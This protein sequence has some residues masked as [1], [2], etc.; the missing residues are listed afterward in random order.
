M[1]RRLRVEYQGAVFHV[2]QRGNNRELIFKSDNDK[3]FFI[4]LLKSLMPVMD[5][6]IY[7]FVLMDNHYHLILRTLQE[8]LQ[9]IMHRI[10]YK[11]SRYFNIKYERK[12]HVFG[13][14]YKAFPVEDEK[15]LLTL[16]RYIHLNPVRA[17][18]CQN[19]EQHHWSSD[20]YYRTNNC[21]FVDVDFILRMLSPKTDRAVSQY[22]R[23]MLA[24]ETENLEQYS[25]IREIS[26]ESHNRTPSILKSLP[27]L[28]EILL[29]VVDCDDDFKLIKKGSRYRN[30]TS[31]KL[32][33]IQKAVEMQY[34]LE[35][36]G[37]N[38]NVSGVAVMDLLRRNNLIT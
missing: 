31:Y 3:A 30:L 19:V 34:T 2:I 26:V 24:E 28:D 25:V 16:L 6:K 10:N 35:D 21:D 8:P 37:A 11:Y 33:Y 12:G 36:I 13:G 5:Y 1:V 9:S 17:G 29:E 18:I 23:F 4:N 7:G 27:S 38:I 14:R 20:Y 15:Y 32:A 22:K